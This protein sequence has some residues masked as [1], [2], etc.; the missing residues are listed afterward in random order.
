LLE[1]L[2][3]LLF[4][5]ELPDDGVETGGELGAE[6][7]AVVVAVGGGELTDAEVEPNVVAVRAVT[8]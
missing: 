2:L 7:G 6:T 4:G 8:V 1:V 3:G 5:L